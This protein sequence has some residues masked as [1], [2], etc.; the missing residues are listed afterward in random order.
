MEKLEHFPKEW[1]EIL[2]C[3]KH[4]ESS[5][6][7]DVNHRTT[8]AMGLLGL[9]PEWKSCEFNLGVRNDCWTTKLYLNKPHA[10]YRTCSD[11]IVCQLIEGGR[12]FIFRDG[13]V[14]GCSTCDGKTGSF[15]TV[16]ECVSLYDLTWWGMGDSERYVYYDIPCDF[17]S[18]ED[19]KKSMTKTQLKKKLFR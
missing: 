8:P 4:W 17:E 14:D 9:V 1:K 5:G 18:F 19:F 13:N 3:T 7:C 15:C 2:L 6:I 12:W 11:D 16:I 10:I